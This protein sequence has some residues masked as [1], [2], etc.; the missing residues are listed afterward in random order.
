[1]SCASAFGQWNSNPAENLLAWPDEHYY[2]SEMQ[3]AP[4]GNLWLG[5]NYPSNGGVCTG[6]QLIDPAG[7]ILFDEPLVVADFEAK[8]WTAFGQILLVDK[9]GNER[10]I[11]ADT[12]ILSAKPEDVGLDVSR[13]YK[14]RIE[15]D[16]VLWLTEEERIGTLGKGAF[17]PSEFG[18]IMPQEQIK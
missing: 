3:I 11:E 7:N 14:L 9:D 15:A 10:F 13:P 2:T 5:M 16:G 1:M 17:S 8:S 12:V 4:N 6:L 18:W